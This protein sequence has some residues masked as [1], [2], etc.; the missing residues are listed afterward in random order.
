[1]ATK[2]LPFLMLGC[3]ACS[4]SSLLGY[5][6]MNSSEDPATGPTGP[7]P[8]GKPKFRYVKI[9]RDKAQHEAAGIPW[10]YNHHINLMEV[11]VISGGVNVALNAAVTASSQHAGIDPMKLT[12]GIMTTQAHTET[13]EIEWFLIDL[14]KEYPIDKVEVINRSDSDSAHRAQGIKIQLS[15][16]ATMS[17]PTES[18]FVSVAQAAQAT[19]KITWIPT[20][21]TLTATAN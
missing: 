13:A 5:L 15:K 8:P 21:K 20:G 18:D 17:T 2:Y 3:V 19:P 10:R 7:A 9:L 6:M 4:S 11:K 12:D 1:M 16:S 14:G